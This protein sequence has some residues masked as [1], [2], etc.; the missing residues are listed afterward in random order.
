[1]ALASVD[2]A[3]QGQ[4]DPATQGNP[5]QNPQQLGQALISSPDACDLT[6]G[7]STAESVVLDPLDVKF[8]KR[9][10]DTE[11]AAKKWGG[12]GKAGD[13]VDD[14]HLK[15]AAEDDDSEGNH[16]ASVGVEGQPSSTPLD[17]LD[18]KFEKRWLDTENAA[19]KWGK[20]KA[21][22]KHEAVVDPIDEA[23]ERWMLMNREP[24]H[25]PAHAASELVDDHDESMPLDPLDAK[26]EKRW[27]DTENA[28]KKWGGKQKDATQPG[29]LPAECQSAQASR[30]PSLTSPLPRIIP[31]TIEACIEELEKLDEEKVDLRRELKRR[32][33]EAEESSAAARE[34]R[35]K[36]TA[37]RIQLQKTLET[38]RKERTPL[39]EEVLVLRTSEATLRHELEASQREALEQKVRSKA[40]ENELEQVK[41]EHSSLTSRLASSAAHCKELKS[42]VVELE[43]QLRLCKQSSQHS[44]PSKQLHDPLDA[45]FEQLWIEQQEKEW[46]AEKARLE[47][48]LAQMQEKLTAEVQLRHQLQQ[49]ADTTKDIQAG[50]HE[51]DDI[52]REELW[53]ILQQARQGLSAK[54][55]ECQVL[56]DT[57]RAFASPSNG[58][59]ASE[60]PAL[61]ATL[62][63]Q[64]AMLRVQ[65]L[66]LASYAKVM[67]EKTSCKGDTGSELGE[68]FHEA[69]LWDDAQELPV[70]VPPDDLALSPSKSPKRPHSSR[71]KQTKAKH[72]S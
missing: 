2:E 66:K 10:L 69:L 1:V 61:I 65:V 37:Q 63:E 55:E 58:H 4:P 62:S 30:S 41:Q 33:A 36:A 47:D 32:E 49:P 42:Y 11:N 15:A 12:K 14:S 56:R 60:Q 18:S 23:F 44:S 51:V 52:A 13:D 45:K 29:D 21:G 7:E 16:E 27:S 59:S 24:I 68:A 22:G 48:D 28:A 19:K 25:D 9:W 34:F 31:Q 3:E 70:P 54:E 5:V 26:F 72:R 38:V 50:P 20:G 17:P 43:E 39:V 57:L 46:A 64:N 71:Q 53:E 6:T 35:K 40:L 8:E 67:Q